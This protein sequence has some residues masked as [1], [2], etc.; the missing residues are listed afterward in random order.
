MH[1]HKAAVLRNRRVVTPAAEALVPAD[2]VLVQAGDRIFA[3]LRL[4]V[5]VIPFESERRYMATLHHDYASHDSVYLKGAPQRVLEMCHF[6]RATGEDRPLD[7]GALAGAGRG[8]RCARLTHALGGVSRRRLRAA[9]AAFRGC[10]GRTHP[11]RA[12]RHNG[13]AA[14][15]E[16]IGAVAACKRA[17]IRVKM[18]TGDHKATAVA[19]ARALGIGANGLALS[20]PERERLDDAALKETAVKTDVYARISPKHK[21]RLVRALESRGE[22]VAMTRNG[23]NDAPALIVRRRRHRHGCQRH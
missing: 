8:A 11:A 19:I 21:L 17:G 22:I 1:S 6:E 12:L 18:I 3:D 13:S 16:A 14:R 10:E 4:R 7:C 20:G 2:V 9:R 15:E 5:D 23:V